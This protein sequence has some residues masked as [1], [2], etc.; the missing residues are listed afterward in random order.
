MNM[1][2]L[3][4]L[5][6]SAFILTGCS[7]LPYHD[8]FA[9]KLEDGYGKCISSDDA[10]TE[11]TTGADMGHAI[12]EDGV[13]N[14]PKESAAKTAANADAQSKPASAAYASYRDRVYEQTAKLIDAPQTPVVRQPTV[15]RTLI[16]SY[17]P[18]LDEQTAYMPRYVFTMLN[19]PKFVLTDYQ[20][21]RDDAAPNFLMGG[22]G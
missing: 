10:Y 17:S 5:L 14:D 8:D 16:L 6:V 1:T 22:K 19:G 9:C 15:V 20:L 7:I 11:A 12:T 3:S 4:L 18:G 2:K 21:S 13:E